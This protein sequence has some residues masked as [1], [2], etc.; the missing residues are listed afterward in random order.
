[1]LDQLSRYKRTGRAQTRWLRHLFMPLLVLSLIWMPGYVAHA[2]T[3]IYGPVVVRPGGAQL[4]DA[5]AGNV[6]TTLPTSTLF[7][8]TGRTEDD[9]WVVGVTYVPDEDDGADGDGVAD[10]AGEPGWLQVAQLIAVGVDLLPIVDSTMP[11][12][13]LSSP[14]IEA[15]PDAAD[16]APNT[17]A[18]SSDTDEVAHNEAVNDETAVI[19]TIASGDDRLNVRSG[20]GTAYAIIAKALPGE[21]YPV[22][23]RT[24]DGAWLQLDRG[25][26]ETGWVSVDY[27]EVAGD[28][29]ALP[30]ARAPAPP[31]TN[32]PTNTP[33]PVSQSAAPSST[34]ATGLSGIMTIQSSP[35][36]M[37]VAYSLDSGALWPLTNGF[38]PAIS[39]DGQ[40][41]T[42]VRD[43]G[44]HG[45]YLID[46]DGSNERLIFSGRERLSS[47]KWSP[48]GQWI[49]FTR[50]DEKY[51]CLDLP[52]SCISPGGIFGGGRG[53]PTLDIGIVTRYWYNLARVDRDGSNY[54]DIASLT[55][56]R[57]AD[58]NEAGIVY[59]SNAGLQLTA[60]VPDAENKLV[61]FDYLKPFF[62]DPD[63]QPNGG[64]IVY[65]GK[66]A[67]HWELFAVNP[68][69]SGKVS[70]TRPAT[71][72][73]DEIPSNVAPA[74][75]PDGQHIAFLSNREADG[76]AG[77]WR[78][79]VMDADGSN[80]RALPINYGTD[81]AI[82]YTF[83][84][85][86][87]ISWVP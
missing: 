85:E 13:S 41:V 70:L 9:L 58:W 29:A 11:A 10:G 48:D 49:L 22:V 71:T 18:A 8:A 40:T 81:I 84:G 25:A 82:N 12:A 28:I 14:A 33:T 32:M 3:P 19:A 53:G 36:G 51:Y 69:G 50:S 27:V 55:S 24:T 42:F 61:I 17:D 65:M 56:A 79:W 34:A 77:T 59:Q 7:I 72:I 26:G 30:I 80:Q 76:E 5:P 78:V 74:W 73:V 47:P 64:R 46:I 62:D 38:D 52:G 83:G 23:G 75:S 6:I 31:P 1:M 15:I 35:G 37:M 68:D 45:V 60:D 39:P 87:S 2:E 16:D 20:P 21:R 54:R 66:E 67:S 43:G 63:W 4:Y 86:Q 44:E 57:A